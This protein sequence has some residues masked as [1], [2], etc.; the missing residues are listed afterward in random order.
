MP[1]LNP[2]FPLVLILFLAI[3]LAQADTSTA[4]NGLLSLGLHNA[5]QRADDTQ[6]NALVIADF[7]ARDFSQFNDADIDSNTQ[8]QL[9]KA[10]YS[11]LTGGFSPAATTADIRNSI[12]AKQK[13]SCTSGYSSPEYLKNTSDSAKNVYRSAL[14]VWRR[15]NDINAAGLQVKVT[16]P[17]NLQSIT[18]DLS[19]KLISNGLALVGVTQSGGNALCNA[20]LPPRNANSRTANVITVDATTYIPFN[21]PST[22]S[23]TC[24][25]DL[26][27]DNAGGKYAEETSLTFKT[28]AGSLDMTMAAI[29]KV[30]RVEYDKAVAEVQR[31]A[32][33]KIGDIKQTVTG[34][35]TRTSDI[36]TKMDG[37]ES[38]I[39]N[40]FAWEVTLPYSSIS[41]C[42]APGHMECMAGAHR[43]CQAHKGK[44]GFIQEW[45]SQ[46][47]AVVCV[48]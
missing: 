1:P 32:D 29:G 13:E 19:T 3:P 20:T 21:T 15:C 8:A 7:C 44:G 16:S 27:D 24:K 48:K 17:T 42:P 4:C 37:V 47:I 22:L 31:V 33:S 25:R 14:E 23:V 12:Q 10:S 18:V 9:I 11:V 41:P 40:G 5:T 43:Y 45:T 36:E 46:A 2:S 26:L 38:V 39:N 35:N 30:P 6:A 28:T 34:L